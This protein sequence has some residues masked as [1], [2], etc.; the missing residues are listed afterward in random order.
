MQTKEKSQATQIYTQ[1]LIE[2]RTETNQHKHMETHKH[3]N[4]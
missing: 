2:I 1:R 4:N 3:E